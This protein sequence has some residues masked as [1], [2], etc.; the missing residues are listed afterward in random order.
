MA[1]VAGLLSATYVAAVAA[2]AQSR[3]QFEDYLQAVA[4]NFSARLAKITLAV[5]GVLAVALGVGAFAPNVGRAGGV[6]SACFLVTATLFHAVRINRAET[7]ACRCFGSIARDLSPLRLPA[8]PAIFSARN[9]A[10]LGASVWVAGGSVALSLGLSLAVALIMGVGIVV[11]ILSE[12]AALDGEIHPK[13]VQLAPT[14]AT[15][16][17]HSWWVNGRPRE[18]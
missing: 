5:E 17:A 8:Q 3:Q 11:S 16:Q 2:K 12:H 10:F 9:T 1:I 15:L 13:A 18:Y 7:T 6:A 14:L 4:A